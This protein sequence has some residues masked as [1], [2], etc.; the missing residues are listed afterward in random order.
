MLFLGEMTRVFTLK[1]LNLDRTNV[2]HK[3]ETRQIGQMKQTNNMAGKTDKPL[4]SGIGKEASLAS[5]CDGIIICRLVMMF[6]IESTRPRIWGN[7]K[8][9]SNLW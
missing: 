4:N 9:L 6:Q 8:L 2:R 1:I 3:N 5:V 7:M